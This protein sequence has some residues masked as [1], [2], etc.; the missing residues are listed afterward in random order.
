[1]DIVVKKLT[2]ALADDFFRLFEEVAFPDYPEWGCKCYCCFFHVGSA[3]QWKKRSGE[4]NRKVAEGLIAAGEMSG[5][6]A[7]A[8]GLPVGWCHFDDKSKLTGLKVF[9]PHLIGGKDRVGSIVCFT[10][11]QDYRRKGVATRLLQG[12]CEELKARGFAVAEA[13]PHADSDDQEVSADE[14]HYHG[15][16]GMYLSHGFEICQEFEKETVV[17]RALK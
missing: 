14:R 17:R 15:P 1:M 7:Y 2:P 6:L 8:D 13:Y 11:A 4:E 9:Y 12:A 10:V 3:E 16:L 5:L